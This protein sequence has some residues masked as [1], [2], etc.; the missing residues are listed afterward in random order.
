MYLQ[1][2]FLERGGFNLKMKKVRGVVMLLYCL[3]FMTSIAYSASGDG[4]SPTTAIKI[5]N[6]SVLQFP[7]G[8]DSGPLVNVGIMVKRYYSLSLNSTSAGDYTS[9]FKQGAKDEWFIPIS[10]ATGSFYEFNV[11]NSSVNG[12]LFSKVGSQLIYKIEV[13]QVYRLPDGR[14]VLSGSKSSF[15]EIEPDTGIIRVKYVDENNNTIADTEEITKPI[16]THTIHSKSIPGYTLDDNSSKQVTLTTK[17]QTVEVVFKYR[18]N[19]SLSEFYMIYTA[20]ISWKNIY[21]TSKNSFKSV[22]YGIA[23]MPINNIKSGYN[24]YYII[25]SKGL[26]ADDNIITEISYTTPDGKTIKGLIADIHSTRKFRPLSEAEKLKYKLTDITTG[27]NELLWIL[28]Y[29]LPI[30]AP[31]GTIVNFK[32]KGY[33]KGDSSNNGFD[34]NIKYNKNPLN[35]IKTKGNIRQDMGTG[36]SH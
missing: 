24:V 16:G 29:T 31:T 6:T 35:V 18:L 30:E 1:K 34:F 8:S 14:D 12:V 10:Q 32:I 9:V 26:K 15:I 22:R 5:N 3:I 13:K 25:K 28:D 36:N 2:L 33:K 20:D 23:D 11:S 19:V 21:Y 27:S 17:G 7:K 4:S